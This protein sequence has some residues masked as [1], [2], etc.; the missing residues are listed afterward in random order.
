M[1]DSIFKNSGITLP[2]TYWVA[3][4]LA[5]DKKSNVTE[6]SG[7]GITVS[8]T[9]KGRKV[10]IPKQITSHRSVVV[11]G[12]GTVSIS[13]A[14]SEATLDTL[15]SDVDE[16]DAA[17]ALLV[18]VDTNAVLFRAS[19]TYLVAYHGAVSLDISNSVDYNPSVVGAKMALRIGGT[20]IPSTAGYFEHAQIPNLTGFVTNE[21]PIEQSVNV[22]GITSTSEGLTAWEGGIAYQETIASTTD[23]D[24]TVDVTTSLSVVETYTPTGTVRGTTSGTALIYV[25]EDADD[26]GALK[27]LD[28][29]TKRANSLTV[30]GTG[31]T[32]ANSLNTTLSITKIN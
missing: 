18:T 14:G 17:E 2:T 21:G 5:E 20:E 15:S 3:K 28:G 32:G 29:A 12:V 25:I 1:D 22:G 23:A 16:A 11:S 13:G 6:I 4:L 8:Q 31:S 26:Y 30:Y 9:P 10:F 19:G 24:Q 27:I 7:P